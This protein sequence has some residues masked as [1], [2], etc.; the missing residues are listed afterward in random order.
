MPA[1]RCPQRYSSVAI[2]HLNKLLD[3][4]LTATFPASHP[5]AINFE[6][7]MTRALNSND[8]GFTPRSE[9]QASQTGAVNAGTG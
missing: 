9:S 5:I 8:T 2:A 3:D 7:G 1:T 4:A 6:L